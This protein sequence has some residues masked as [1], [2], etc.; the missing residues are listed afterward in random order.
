MLRTRVFTI[1]TSIIM[2][3]LTVSSVPAL[4]LKAEALFGNTG[5]AWAGDTPIPDPD[6][7]PEDNWLYGARISI[8]EAIGDGI[9]LETSYET[10]TVLRHILR[11][12][13]AYQAG[14]VKLSA[15]PIM[16]LF[17]TPETPLK[18]G[19][20]TGLRIDAPGLAFV[21]MRADSSLG[22]GLY[23]EGDYAQE[24]GELSAGWYVRNAICA[25]T[26][27]T[28]TMYTKTDATGTLGDST[29][30]YEFSVDTFRK[31]APYRLF[32]AMGYEEF[33]R[34]Y[35]N[36]TEPD[37]LGSIFL[38]GRL[39]ADLS[40]TITLVAGLESA[41]YS[42]GLD[43]LSGRGPDPSAFL[44]KSSLGIRYRLESQEE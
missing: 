5:F 28:K 41:I 30:R 6:T 26:I 3:V 37:T 35:P 4:D 29:N 7:F 9:R 38:G 25:V 12:V 24:L 34:T 33:T 18:A 19:I 15:G 36:V 8:S 11:S 20:S 2:L 31:S 32:L 23:S 27:L 22:A 42:F 39:N 40:P 44:F 13:I 21:S 14:V 43:E 1:Y 16:G 17:N 10:D